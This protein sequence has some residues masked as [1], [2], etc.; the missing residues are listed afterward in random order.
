MKTGQAQQLIIVVLVAQRYR[1]LR[2]Q[3][4]FSSTQPSALFDAAKGVFLTDPLGL[5]P[6]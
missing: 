6:K 1:M 4:P 2:S 3:P 5:L